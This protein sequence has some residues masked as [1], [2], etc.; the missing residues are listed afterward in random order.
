MLVSVVTHILAGKVDVYYPTMV[1][2]PLQFQHLGLWQA[3]CP[4]G[5][6]GST[7]QVYIDGAHVPMLTLV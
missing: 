2:C 1:L 4:F 3:T 5:Y 7:A 6:V